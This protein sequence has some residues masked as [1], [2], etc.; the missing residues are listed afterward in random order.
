M[1]TPTAGSARGARSA[2]HGRDKQ[3]DHYGRH[4]ARAAA[5]F[6]RRAFLGTAGAAGAAGLLGATALQ[7][8]AQAPV[9][10]ELRIITQRI[11]P[12]LDPVHDN[13]DAIG[14]ALRSLGAAEGL[15]RISATAEP[16]LELA[17]RME[18]VDPTT[19]V[20]ALRPGV[21]FWSGRAVD[22][23][24]VV[25]SLERSRALALPAAALLQGVRIDA[26]DDLT[27]RFQSDG[28]LPGLP[29]NLANEWLVIHN[30]QTY[31]PR[32]N[33]FD[34]GAADLT[35]AFRVT[36]FEPGER[37]L[38]ARNDGYWGVPARMQRVRFEQIVDTDARALAA[39][40]GEA[41]SVRTIAS[42]FAAQIDRSRTMRLV[43]V[44]NASTGMV[45]LN[46]AKP[47][48]DEVRVRQA[49]AWAVDRDEMVELAHDGR[50]TPYP[51]WLAAHPSYP[52]ARKVGYVRQDLAKAAQLLDQ[53]G[54]RLAPGGRVRAKDGV[55]L[56]FRVYWFNL[57]RPQAEILQA[58]WARVGAEV[59]V[60]GT[61][62][63][64][65]TNTR[66]AAG[67]WDAIIEQ[68]N[69]VGDP[70]AV[71]S[72]HVGASGA[73]NYARFQDAELE[74]LLA[75]F[76][77]LTEPEARHEQALR[78]NARHAEL[79]PFIPLTSQDR[80]TA[81]NRRVRNYAP[82]FTVWIYE[83]HPD[84]WVATS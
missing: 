13:G 39:L 55:P 15:L 71:L 27:V 21:R 37:T 23:G 83:V 57:N 49:L 50:G 75:G 64:S 9:E 32:T 67:D 62:D 25:E 20:V 29:L 4:G 78:V 2:R 72:R 30:A 11:Q 79:V 42:S 74:H 10:A 73:L 8:G 24:A 59:E 46:T 68:W 41:H 35:G 6:R 28:P 12:G 63:A 69:T 34:V 52:E 14:G 38:L 26:P 80:L 44:T 36:A 65:F 1:S 47:P 3:L 54:W 58:Q 31:G 18:L 43:S 19:W 60:Q 45:Y 81:V 56:R 33:S 17:S 84:L 5:G 77:A 7:A 48:F 40:A 82:H 22:A 70:A 76:A 61:A 66:R 53:A 16:E 51:S